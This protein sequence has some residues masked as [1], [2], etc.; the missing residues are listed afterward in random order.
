MEFWPQARPLALAGRSLRHGAPD[1][2]GKRIGVECLL[3]V[4]NSFCYV[5][6]ED[7][8]GSTPARNDGRARLSLD[9]DRMDGLAPG[10]PAPTRG[11]LVRD[12]ARADLSA[13]R[14]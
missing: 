7:P 12:R 8:L 3:R 6:N 14:F 5:R 9:S 1:N 4:R 2:D 10:V 11:S 13:A